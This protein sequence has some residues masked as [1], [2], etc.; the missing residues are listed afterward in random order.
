ME[1]TDGVLYWKWHVEGSN[2][3]QK[4]LVLPQGL[5]GTILEQLHDSKLSGGDFVF[6][7]SLDRARQSFWWQIGEKTLNKNVRTAPCIKHESSL[8]RKE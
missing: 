2:T 8:E 3:T 4:Q 1:M 6:Q 5:R 7:K